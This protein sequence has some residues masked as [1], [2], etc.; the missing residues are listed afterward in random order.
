MKPL[1]FGLLT[2][3][4]VA[5]AMPIAAAEPV[6]E[7]ALPDLE[8]TTTATDLL[9]QTEDAA[10]VITDVQI[11]PTPEGFTVVLVSDQPLS[12]GTSEIVGNALVTN[13][14]N[15]TL[16]LTDEAAAEQFSPAEG[17]AL[18]QVTP[19]PDGGVQVAITGTDA[20]PAAQVNPQANNLVFSVEPGI[21]SA[22]IE[23]A[24]TIQVVV[25]ATRTEEDVLDVPRTVR[26]IERA[27]IQQQLEL[28]NNLPDILGNLV[29]GFSPPPL[30]I[31]TRG[32]TLRGR[33]IQVLVDGVP[34]NPNGPLFFELNTIS[35]DSLERIE[36]IPGA[37]A[38]YGDGAAG[39]TINLIT[40]APVEEGV[41]YRADI[42]T[43]VGLTSIEGDSFGYTVGLDVAGAE[44]GVDGR[45]SVNYDVRNAQFDAN[46]DRIIPVVGLGEYDR[47]GLLTK[48]GYDIDENQRIGLTYSFYRDQ[49]DSEFTSD[50]A[51]LDIPGT[52]VAR[53]LFLGEFDYE[54]PPKTTSNVLNLTY[55]H[56]DI[57]GS[58]LDA[59]VYY[60]DLEVVQEFG[61][62]R[63]RGF[64]EFFP[65]IFQNLNEFSELGLRM[66][67]DTPLGNAA[68]VLWGVDYSQEENENRAAFID[69]VAF[70][71]NREVN[72]IEEFS[73]FPLY[74]I[75]NLGLFAQTRWDI[76][77]QW[78][79]SGG[80]RYDN[81]SFS[82]DPYQLAFQ[83]PRE[84]DGGS[85]SFDD[86]SFNVGL[87]YRPIPEVGLFANFSQGFSIPSLG[88]ALG[89]VAPD[90]DI[91]DDLLFQP[92]TVDNFELGARAEFGRVQAS[93][94]G[95]YSESS[96]GAS[97]LFDPEI[98][99]T[100]LVRAPQRNY[101]VEATIDW[102]PS[103][104]WRLG[105][106]F[107]WAE[108]EN[109]V[110]D[111]GDF[112]PLGS[113]TVPPYKLGLYVEN[114][115]TPRWTNRLQMLL[116]GDRDRAFDEGIDPFKINSYVT[117]DLISS[118]QLGSGRLTLAVENL[119]NTEYL[120][121]TAQERVNQFE[122]RRFAAPGTTLSVRYSIEF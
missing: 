35:P 60:T 27:A 121:L 96:L 98:G 16:A 61:D 93:V 6:A 12:A 83:F 40:R 68:N 110:G 50:P 115:T 108:G 18:V 111:E 89:Q 51:I 23:D 46:G 66:Q 30:Q 84:R 22:V 7:I 65:E 76:S 62:I 97:F 36:V 8:A 59:Q 105:G 34:Q 29:P 72:I 104:T 73:A 52:Q 114:N 17:I 69:P 88:L 102:Q 100:R 28:T 87:L 94:A 19:L 118:L 58:Q 26:I 21:A 32:F 99:G 82:A 67:V 24:D 107:S 106:A 90:F 39:G 41:I 47:L 75:E 101:G 45:I 117:L 37:S 1:S 33:N 57:F 53:P 103:D 10:A 79:I 43:R 31:G 15:A 48:L 44:N 54:E 92:Q 119:L 77:E 116:I 70:D 112:L 3:A 81:V 2:I 49:T 13:I 14:P 95:F 42:G 4:G 78:Q 122:D 86:V 120:S 9:A 113:L 55:R 63:F 56:A 71:A 74:E 25:T 91:S 109:D 85:G 64:P 11:E 20:P 38:L 5:I 80:I